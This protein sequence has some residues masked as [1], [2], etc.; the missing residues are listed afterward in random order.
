M[1]ERS[2]TASSAI[3]LS[4]SASKRRRCLPYAAI[5]MASLLGVASIHR[6]HFAAPAAAAHPRSSAAWA[7]VFS[8]LPLSFETNVGQTDRQVS[9]LARGHGYTLFLTSQEVLL[10]LRNNKRETKN[11]A[12]A[13]PNSPASRM[14][15]SVVHLRLAR[16]NSQPVISG[17]EQLSGHAN[18]FLGNNPRQWHS[19][20]PTYAKVKY[21]SVYPGVDLVYYGNQSGQ[22]EYD[23]VVA[24]GADPSAIA[25]NVQ[26]GSSAVPASKN[27]RVDAEGD[28]VIRLDA[29]DV[30]FHKPVVYQ[31]ASKRGSAA[32]ARTTVDGRYVLTASNEVR[33]ALGPYDHS[34]PLVIDPSLSYATYVGGSGGDIGYAIAVDSN[35]DAYITGVTN[36][37][38]FPTKGAEQGTNKTNGDAFVTKVNAEG[39]ALIY[40]TYIGGSGSDTAAAI[41]VYAGDVYITGNTT[42][43]DFPNT[44][45]QSGSTTVYPFQTA[46]AGGTDA[47]VAELNTDGSKLVFSS[48]LGGSGADFGQG[49]AVDSASNVYVTGSTQSAN[50]PTADALQGSSGGN[51]DAFLTVINL[52]GTAILYSTY[53]GGS[54][55]DVAQAIHVT[56][57]GSNANV[58]LA[59]YTFSADFPVSSTPY[60]SATA[61]APDA[62]VSELA[63]TG[64]NTASVGSSLTFSTYFGGEGDDRAYGLAVDGSGNVYITGATTSST[65][66]PA[67]TGSFQTNNH[68]ASDAF[69]AKLSSG[70]SSLVYASYLGGTGVDQG[71]AIAVDSAGDAFVTGFTQSD[72]FPTASA[73]QSILGI[74]AGSL[75]GASACADAFVTEFNANGTA[76][77]YSTYL[78]GSSA[79]FGQGI[80]LD[81][82]GLAY[83]TGS[84]SSTNFPA[85]AGAFQSSLTGV[86][87]NAFVAKVDS[88]NQPTISIVPG[89]INFG[90]ETLNVTSALQQ[91]TITNPSTQPLTITAIEFNNP[92]STSNPAKSTYGFLETNTCL[93]TLP[94]GG[95]TCTINVSFT[96]ASVS[97]VTDQLTITDNAY[98]A[99]TSS[100]TQ[101]ITFTGTGVTAATAVTVTPTSLTFPNQTISTTSAAQTVSITNTGTSTLNISKIATTGDFTET[102]TCSALLYALSV[103]QSC[104]VSVTFSPSATGTRSGSLTISDNATGSPQTVALSGVGLA[105]FSLTSPASAN[106]N[107]VLIGTTSTTF[108]IVAGGDTSFTGKISLACSSGTTC[109]FSPTTVGVGGVST[110]TVSN[111]TTTMANPYAFTV[112][113]VSGSQTSSVQIN[114][115]FEDYTLSSTPASQTIISGSSAT[116]TILVNPLNGLT[117]EQIRLACGNGAPPA[118]SCSFS[119]ATPSPS[120]SASSIKLTLYTQKY[121]SE[122]HMPPP[123]PPG[124]LPPVILGLLSLVGLASLALSARRRARRGRLG[125]AW[126]GVRLAAIS[127]ILVLNLALG[128]CRPSALATSGTTTGFYTVT[129]TGTLV[130]NEAVVRTTSIILTVT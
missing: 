46:N 129:I 103:G 107:P 74:S 113:G 87:G 48:Y 50:F 34:Q 58:Y 101:T 10:T 55:A 77:T 3:S 90:N 61:G 6:G 33:F 39:T 41:A 91:V 102:D 108:Q 28:L 67:T 119:N 125:P 98:V 99:G 127:L 114:L 124:K 14:P 36:S 59:G 116:Y 29:G 57:S 11:V 76:L 9:F 52:S 54:Q 86:V 106:D 111:L 56:A 4:G 17:V 62:F 97:S 45:P 92:V 19:D 72:D 20:V 13:T 130:S 78:G 94:A 7:R 70:G 2:K 88:L 49:I 110:L 64:L 37:S 95:G 18:Y 71:N 26:T 35:D 38:N 112:T 44:A 68:G 60:Q 105:Q 75:C 79:D 40:S 43:T 65:T 122:T 42:S 80:A 66:F 25:L 8:A 81:S 32:G 83:V 109:T 51:G 12:A 126:L 21:Q 1:S 22:L 96:P 89:K 73:L 69:V 121:V 118:S 47:F 104:S 31:L 128:S 16:A 23:F 5:L 15:D 84:T 63:I 117:G 115:L 123:L 30:R 82:S 100:T 85:I 27:L 24:P 53:L 120:G 93:G